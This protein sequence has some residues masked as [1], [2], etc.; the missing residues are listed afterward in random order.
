MMRVAHRVVVP[1]LPHLPPAAVLRPLLHNELATALA[2]LRLG[3][4]GFERVASIPGAYSF[5]KD[6]RSRRV[7]SGSGPRTKPRKSVSFRDG[8]VAM[9][10]ISVATPENLS[11][12]DRLQIPKG[13]E[14]RW[15]PRFMAGPAVQEEPAEDD[16]C[17]EARHRC[18]CAKC[19]VV[20]SFSDDENE[21]AWL[22]IVLDGVDSN[23]A[24][25]MF[26]NNETELY[27]L[28][29]PD[30]EECEEQTS[31]REWFDCISAQTQDEE[32]A[33]FKI[34]Q[35]LNLNDVK[36]ELA[37]MKT[38]G[39][40]SADKRAALDEAKARHKQLQVTID[41]HEVTND[42]HAAE[43]LDSGLHT[44]LMPR[45]IFKCVQEECAITAGNQDAGLLSADSMWTQHVLGEREFFENRD[46][47]RKSRTVTEPEGGASHCVDYA[48][49]T[50]FANAHPLAYHENYFAEYLEEDFERRYT[51]I[52]DGRAAD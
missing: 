3:S 32:A 8:G 18:P 19:K 2:E 5:S 48:A 50:A 46:L 22:E 17:C 33:I 38:D 31:S 40:S 26:F 30:G 4:D 52:L 35:R 9:G 51:Y 28:S 49:R 15:T 14:H 36:E 11:L 47:G 24:T 43:P 13:K 44:L 39:A 10:K 20:Y 41:Q 34:V 29:L 16:C 12:E 37:N 25:S 23:E 27:A 45:V 42:L 1:R 6:V 21:P 7:R